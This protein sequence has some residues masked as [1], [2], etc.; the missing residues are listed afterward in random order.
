[1]KSLVPH[2]YRKKLYCVKNEQGECITHIRIDL[3]Q[4]NPIFAI[5]TGLISNVFMLDIFIDSLLQKDKKYV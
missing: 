4:K 2:T 1:M 5:F 3:A